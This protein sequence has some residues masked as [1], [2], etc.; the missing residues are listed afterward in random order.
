MNLTV[1]ETLGGSSKVINGEKKKCWE[2]NVSLQSEE[3][4]LGEKRELDTRTWGEEK[5]LVRTAVTV[6]IE[7]T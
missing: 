3:S 7:A 5:R 1:W 2:G 4:V 6:R